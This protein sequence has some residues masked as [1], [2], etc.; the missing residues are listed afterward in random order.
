MASSTN[1]FNPD[2]YV[3]LSNLQLLQSNVNISTTGEFVKTSGIQNIRLTAPIYWSG[4]DAYGK[5]DVSFRITKEEYESYLTY[6]DNNIKP[7]LAALY[8]EPNIV[9]LGRFNKKKRNAAF[10]VNHPSFYKDSKSDNGGMIVKFRI[11]KASIMTL[12]KEGEDG[13]EI[14]VGDIKWKSIAEA[15]GFLGITRD[16]DGI[17]YLRLNLTRLYIKHDPELENNGE[18]DTQP[19]VPSFFLPSSYTLAEALSEI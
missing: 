11:N 6:Y 15:F 18:V 7:K 10:E 9:P 2:R 1:S 14:E 16:K 17:F 13:Y 12:V 5:S 19:Y 4:K 8:P 3:S